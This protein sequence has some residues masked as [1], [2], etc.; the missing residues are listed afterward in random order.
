M[1]DGKVEARP[2]VGDCVQCG[3]DFWYDGADRRT[4]AC[5]HCRNYVLDAKRGVPLCSLTLPGA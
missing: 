2:K 1:A 5:V 3:S 4:E